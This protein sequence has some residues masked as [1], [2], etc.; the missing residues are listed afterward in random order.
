MQDVDAK[1]DGRE[2]NSPRDI[3]W[4]GWKD[5]FWR[6]WLETSQDRL[7]I[8]ASSVA[9][10]GLLA[11]FPA[12][13]SIVAI[14]GLVADPADVV[15][16]MNNYSLALPW[17]ARSLITEQL[18]EIVKGSD[19]TLTVGVVV[20]LLFS[21][22]SAS[23]GV[24]A[25]MTGVNI[26]Y[27]EAETRGWLR[28]RFLAL[29]FTIGLSLF[30]IVNAAVIAL[31]PS[32]LEFIGLG[33][34]TRLAIGLLRWPAMGAGV[35][36]GL[37]ILYRY[38]PDRTPP[39]W[40]WVAW[41]AALATAIW[42]VASLVFSLYAE[43]LGR[44]NK[45]YG[46]IGGVVVLL[47][48]LFISSLAILLGAEL[49]AELEHQTELDTTIGPPRPMGERDA[50]MADTLGDRRPSRDSKTMSETVTGVFRDLTKQGNRKRH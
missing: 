48:W 31:L 3:P 50:Q 26:A 11:L 24:A 17:T 20:G 19:A 18:M 12:L 23:S 41:G 16:Q 40:P 35:M 9:F 45:T 1:L 46:A 37:C 29:S 42:F 13:I 6:V 2:A 36:L 21:L 34:A 5:V 28:L 15:R 10:Y 33:A 8:V 14:Y 39:K 47:L 44:F 43:N 27:G 32:V 30:V 7:T 22:F 25:L 49:N 4:D 38:A